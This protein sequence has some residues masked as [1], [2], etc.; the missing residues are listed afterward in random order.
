MTLR[1]A[2]PDGKEFPASAFYQQLQAD[3]CVEQGVAYQAK[4]KAAQAI[5][6]Y[7]RALDFD[8]GRGER[9]PPAC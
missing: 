1:K 2:L 7:S 9:S 5:E 6:A 3:I 8:P 4:G